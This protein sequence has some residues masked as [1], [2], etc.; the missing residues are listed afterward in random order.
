MITTTTGPKFKYENLDHWS[1]IY[2]TSVFITEDNA[3]YQDICTKFKGRCLGVMIPFDQSL[4]TSFIKKESY[5][6]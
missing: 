6:S 2:I 3:E 5:Y 4:F 1:A